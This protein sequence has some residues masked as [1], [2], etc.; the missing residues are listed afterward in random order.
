MNIEKDT[1]KIID[2]YFK[3]TPNYLTKHHIDSFNDFLSEKI[4]SIFNDEDLNPQIIPFF[5]KQDPN[6]QYTAKIY[7]GGKSQEG[8]YISKPII[9]DD[10]KGE[11]RPLYPNE[12]RLKKL[13]YAVNVFCDIDIEY[14]MKIDNEYKYK[15]VACPVQIKKLNLGRVPLMLHSEACPLYRVPR[16]LRKKMGECI[17]DHGGYFVI[18]GKEKVCISR[19][20]K[21]ENMLYI[22]KS[23]HPHYSWTLDIKSVPAEFRYARN[24]YLHVIEK[25]GEIFFENTYFKNPNKNN[26]IPLMIIFRAFGAESDKEIMEYIFNDLDSEFARK[27]MEYLIPSFN[28]SEALEIDDQNSSYVYLEHFMKGIENDQKD[29]YRNRTARLALLMKNIVDNIF[30]HVGKDLT[31]KLHYLGYST[32]QLLKCI[33]GYKNETDR[34]SFVYKRVDLSGFMIANLFRD[35]FKQL[36]YDANITLSTKYEFSSQT[37]KDYDF[38]NL[39]TDATVKEVFKTASL[40]EFVMKAFRTGN[41]TNVGHINEKK[42]VIQQ[43]DRRGYLAHTSLMRR[44]VTPNDYDT[45]V[46]LDQRRLHG[47]QYG[48]LCSFDIMDGSNVGVKKHFTLL[49]Q[50]TAGTRKGE[51]IRCIQENNLIPLTDIH[52]SLIKGQTKVFVNGEWIGIHLEPE[53]LVNKLRLLRRNALINIYTSIAW[54]VNDNEIV[55][56]TDGGRCV[57]PLYIVENNQLMINQDLIDKVKTKKIGWYN[58]IG[59]KKKKTIDPSDGKYYRPEENGFICDTEE[60]LLE[61]LRKNSGVI[62]YLDNNEIE[63]V[64]LSTSF[65]MEDSD[66]EYTHCELHA[67]MILSPLAHCVPYAGTNQLPRNVYGVTQCKHA[68]STMATNY[69]NRIETAAMILSYPQKPLINTRVGKY[70]YNDRLGH[71]NNIIVAVACFTGYN[72]EDSII[73]NKSSIDR[74]LLRVSYFRQY[75]SEEVSDPKTGTYEKFYNPNNTSGNEVQEDVLPSQDLNYENIDQYGFIKEGTYCKG[76]EVVASKFIKIT[77]QDIPPRD[78]SLYS[79]GGEL[80]D[81]VFTT[82]TDNQKTRLAKVRVV[83]QRLPELGDKVGS[84][85]GQKGCCGMFFPEE[86]MPVT[87]DGIVPD[88]IINPQA[89]PKRMTNGQ[90]IEGPASLLASALGINLDGTTFEHYDLNLIGDLLEQNGC[91][92]YGEKVLYDGFEGRQIKA[93]IYMCPTF[94]Q[95][96]KQMVKDKI[97]SRTAGSRIE[98]VPMLGGGY[99]ARERQPYAGRALGGG[100]RVGEM[101]RD[102]IIAHG[103]SAFMKETLM[104][105]SDKYFYYVSQDTGR[106]VICNPEEKIYYDPDMDGPMSYN[107]VDVLDMDVNDKNKDENNISNKHEILGVNTFPQ[108]HTNFSKIYVPFNCK[109]LVQ[110]LEAMGISMRIITEGS[111]I[112]KKYP[113][114]NTMPSKTINNIRQDIINDI[115]RKQQIEAN[116]TRERLEIDNSKESDNKDDKEKTDKIDS[117]DSKSDNT[118]ERDD[119]DDIYDELTDM[120]GGGEPR[121]VELFKGDGNN[122]DGNNQTQLH[123]GE[124]TN[125]NENTANYDEERSYLDTLNTRTQQIH[126]G[127]QPLPNNNNQP[128]P[129]NNQP[130]NNQ[131]N[132]NHNQPLSNNNQPNQPNQP[133]PNINQSIQTTQSNQPQGG[134]GEIKVVS[135]TLPSGTT[136]QQMRQEMNGESRTQQT[137]GNQNITNNQTTN[138]QTTDN[139]NQHQ[140]VQV[141]QTIQMEEQVPDGLNEI[142]L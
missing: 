55:C 101:E 6:K 42:G 127:E 58:L 110:E 84:R 124:T 141:E 36:R 44:L 50:V 114:K 81:K 104:E 136:E 32:N 24:S 73:F 78:I 49:C 7:Y 19:E 79:E 9:Y 118:S 72:Q 29:F 112:S 10:L 30:P 88:I 83:K 119:I 62:E 33:L 93:N 12:A 102:C 2:S 117:I 26:L 131:S 76:K 48:Y 43:A 16:E 15:D 67:S 91:N 68:I 59:G 92:R 100:G 13:N 139:Q 90:L 28:N 25:T 128:L 138:N 31:A 142:F 53:K 132:N 121:V 17:Y 133:N 35:G 96:F 57:R 8:I 107:L 129:N 113:I 11:N 80:V 137:G 74:G 47:T 14:S 140:N 61:Q 77:R 37:L 23:S 51:L 116:F 111:N 97:H 46:Q 41:M 89:F 20:R 108:R 34:D 120:S 21:A 56:W 27:G 54:Y 95:R 109:L 99:M 52:P 60:E 71:G 134:G 105:R 3:E 98:D 125:S 87:D 82:Y 115:E 38:I 39:I 103:I 22:N 135:V 1:W 130:N 63:N 75:T 86:D 18:D 126:G 106:Q 64:M 66:I 40:E 65:F 45:R 94:Y 122:N 70:L 123:G 85:Y 69:M 5:D 4:R